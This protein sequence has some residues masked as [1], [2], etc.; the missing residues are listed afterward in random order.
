MRFY[1]YKDIK[2][3]GLDTN[4]LAT[5]GSLKNIFDWYCTATNGIDTYVNLDISMVYS[6]RDLANLQAIALIIKS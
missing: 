6:S 2:W 4:A 3:N 1:G 5:S